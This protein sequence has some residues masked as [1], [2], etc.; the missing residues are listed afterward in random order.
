MESYLI[1]GPMSMMGF[2]IWLGCW[3]PQSDMVY[4]PLRPW[5][6][7]EAVRILQQSA[8]WASKPGATAWLG[9][10]KEGFERQG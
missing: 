5:D 6:P 10:E 3:G 4:V 2:Y 1:T 8:N 7:E 9:P